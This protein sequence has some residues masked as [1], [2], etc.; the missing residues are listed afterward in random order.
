MASLAQIQDWWEANVV[1]FVQQ[2]LETFASFRHKDEL[3]PLSDVDGLAAALNGK[4]A[5]A[6]LTNKA[7]LIDGKIPVEQ[8]P[9]DTREFT[10]SVNFNFTIPP[11]K[12]LSSII[13]V[14]TYDAVL[15]IGTSNGGTDILDGEEIVNG[16]G[17]NNPFVLNK[18]FN[19]AQTIYVSGFDGDIYFKFIIQ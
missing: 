4:A 17:N 2:R 12:L 8:L 3:V 9:N 11:N 13:I 7:D 18:W 16:G 5:A 19:D 10:R 14:P 6:S 15:N 1:P